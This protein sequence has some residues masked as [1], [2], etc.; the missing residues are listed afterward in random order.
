MYFALTQPAFTL[1]GNDRGTLV[2]VLDERTDVLRVPSGAISTINGEAV[3]YYQSESGFK[4]Y[5]NV[6][7]GLEA[8]GMVEIISGLE[9]GEEVIVS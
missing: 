5:K 2:L 7:I 1:E 6:T 3:V 8:E 9:E 4:T